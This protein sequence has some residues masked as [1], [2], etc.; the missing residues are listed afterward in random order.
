MSLAQARINHLRARQLL[1]NGFDP[2]EYKKENKQTKDDSTLQ[3]K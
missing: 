3:V 1:A 2:S